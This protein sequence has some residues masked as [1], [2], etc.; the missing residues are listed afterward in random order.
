M[1]TLLKQTTKLSIPVHDTKEDDV[2]LCG[3]LEQQNPALATQ[4]RRLAL[5]CDDSLLALPESWGAL[6]MIQILHGHMG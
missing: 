2:V 5:V 3:L 1:A 4:G 6:K